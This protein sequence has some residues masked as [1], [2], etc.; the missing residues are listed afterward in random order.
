MMSTRP[1]GYRTVIRTSCPPYGGV[2]V[3]V[4]VIVPSGFVVELV[5]NVPMGLASATKDEP[6]SGTR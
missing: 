6:P 2:T 4:T 5:V 1:E 3:P